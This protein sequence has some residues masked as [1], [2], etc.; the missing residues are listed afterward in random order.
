MDDTL[1]LTNSY[2]EIL[3]FLSDEV[4]LR[5]ATRLIASVVTTKTADG[6][7][8]EEMLKKHLGAWKDGKG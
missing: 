8:T 1:K 7:R 2:W 5:L 4:K 6:D 3:K